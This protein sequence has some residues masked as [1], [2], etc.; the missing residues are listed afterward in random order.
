PGSYRIDVE[1]A[2]FQRFIRQPINVEVQNVTRIDAKLEVGDVSQ[3]IEVTS[4]T[5]VLQSQE[6]VLGQT[7]EGRFV[8]E[9]PLNGR[10]VMNLVAL[11]P[12][13]IPQGATSGFGGLGSGNFQIGGGIANQSAQFA[14]G[15]PLNVNYFHAVAYVPTQDAVQEFRV[16]TNDIGVETG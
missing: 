2:G 4:Q 14:D 1:N 3:S 5:P 12:G 16:Q 10:N 13:V 6:A 8:N 15:A 7:I 9:I 11:V